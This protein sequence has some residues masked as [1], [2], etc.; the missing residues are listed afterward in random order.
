MVETP[1]V[2]RRDG[3]PEPPR[4]LSALC[5]AHAGGVPGHP[6]GAGAVR[7]APARAHDVP[8]APA[9]AASWARARGAARSAWR[10]GLARP[11]GG[12]GA[13]RA[14]PTVSLELYH[15]QRCR[16]SCITANGVA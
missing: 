3:G 13:P 12:H 16:L 14:A 1:P 9:I 5:G 7:P 10:R 6:A 11:G 2:R 8:D 4:A 15:G